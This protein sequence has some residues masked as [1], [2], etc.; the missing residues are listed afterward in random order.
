MNRST[1]VSIVVI[2][3][4][5]SVLGVVGTQA[6]FVDSQTASGTVNA[7][8]ADVDLRLNDVSLPCG[9]SNMSEDEVTFEAIEDLVP[10]QS[11][12]CQVELENEGSQ[13]F[14]VD[15]NAIDT[16]AAILDLCD[17]PGDEFVISVA[18]AVDTDGDDPSATSVRVAPAIGDTV[19]IQVSFNAGASNG[20]QG[21]AAFVSVGFTATSIP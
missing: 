7:A 2:L 21:L 13:P 15:L 3:A 14:D 18:K 11:V 5:L 8:P 10:G 12:T 20:C 1:L 16:S 17:G 4:S 6:L 9:I 19:A